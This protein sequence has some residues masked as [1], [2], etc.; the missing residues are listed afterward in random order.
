[1]FTHLSGSNCKYPFVL[2]DSD[3]NLDFKT[4]IALS[5]THLPF[6]KCLLY[7]F[8]SGV[9]SSVIIG[10][11]RYSLS[12]YPLSPINTEDVPL[13]MWVF[14]EQLSHTAASFTDPGHLTTAFKN[15]SSASQMTW[16]M[17]W[18]INV[19]CK[20][21]KNK[22]KVLTKLGLEPAYESGALTSCATG[23]CTTSE[24]IGRTTYLTIQGVKILSVYIHL[25]ISVGAFDGDL[26]AV[27]CSYAVRETRVLDKSLLH[28]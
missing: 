7:L 28:T 4:P 15:L 26:C 22:I 18:L 9:K 6:R 2:W 27:H 21:F 20:Y 11:R 19:T 17:L 12:G 14:T 24:L 3:L 25:L 16:N 8:S 5:I 10:R 1:M 23:A 13:S